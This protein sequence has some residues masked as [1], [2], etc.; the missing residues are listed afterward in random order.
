MSALVQWWVQQWVWIEPTLIP[1]WCEP[2]SDEKMLR[3]VLYEVRSLIRCIHSFYI[4]ATVCNT[5]STLVCIHQTWIET[6]DHYR[7]VN[8]G[9]LLISYWT[10]HSGDVTK[11]SLGKFSF[12]VLLELGISIRVKLV[13]GSFF[14]DFL[15][16]FL[17]NIFFLSK[18]KTNK[19]VAGSFF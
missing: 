1:G 10:I 6:I 9:R 7:K 18:K 4:R 2:V 5:S 19:E 8:L 14:G 11:L 16:P 15:S 17:N 3:E 12:R 13:L